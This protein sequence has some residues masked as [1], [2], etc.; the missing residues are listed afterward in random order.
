MPVTTQARA[1]HHRALIQDSDPTHTRPAGA[2]QRMRLWAELTRQRT[3][4]LADTHLSLFIDR[5]PE[6]QSDPVDQASVDRERS[7]AIQVRIRTLDQ[8]RRIERALQ[9]MR[10]ND[11]GRC[12]HCH[13][14]IPYKRLMIKPDTLFCVPCL[15]RIEQGAARN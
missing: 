7:L 10:S 9:L 5:E 15:T 4:L 6:T 11:Y 12:Q 13:G 2:M 14:K 1:S 8:L 3:R